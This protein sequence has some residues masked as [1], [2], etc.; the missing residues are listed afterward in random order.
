MCIYIYMCNHIKTQLCHTIVTAGLLNEGELRAVGHA[1]PSRQS[2]E[3][4]A[5]KD[6]RRWIHPAK[7][8]GYSWILMGYSWDDL[9]IYP[10]VI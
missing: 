1:E 3:E 7:N 5:G 9:M 10:L 6:L 8:M 4:D 2:G